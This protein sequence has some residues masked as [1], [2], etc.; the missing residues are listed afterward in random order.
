[1]HDQ[2]SRK[3]LHAAPLLGG[4]A[5]SVAAE[6]ATKAGPTQI[7]DVSLASAPGYAQRV[8]SPSTHA[9]K[10]ADFQGLS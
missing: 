10:M 4:R 3:G 7:E 9:S 8:R 5:G 6:V 2:T 1:M